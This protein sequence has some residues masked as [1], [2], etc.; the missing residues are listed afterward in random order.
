MRNVL[1]SGG[2]Y[3]P[4]EQTSDWLA[5]RFAAHGVESVSIDDVGE[6][7]SE[8]E[9]AD[10]LTIN[11]LRWRMLNHDKYI[12]HRKQWAFEMPEAWATR[13]HEF[14]ASGGAL[15]GLHTASICFD[16]WYDYGNLLGGRW[17]WDQSF[18]PPPGP[19]EVRGVGA[20]AVSSFTT[21]DEIYHHLALGADSE[22]LLEGRCVGESAAQDWQTLAWRRTEGD[23]RVLY[24]ALG[25]DAAALAQ[26]P[27]A[28]FIDE[29]ISWL[30]D[31]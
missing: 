8:L 28:K 4:F 14:V 27:M 23:G 18:H 5:Q 31:L 1:L 17:V 2:I 9:T 7:V 21:E 10:C 15:L 13:I 25:H 26:A 6:A 24:C 29:S 16:T 11:A 12:P 22:R 3:H 30:L 20:A 19:C